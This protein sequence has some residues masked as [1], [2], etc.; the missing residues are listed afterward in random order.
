MG[1]VRLA[2]R[3]MATSAL[4]ALVVALLVAPAIVAAG[5][6]VAVADFRYTPPT[7]T[8]GVGEAVTWTMGNDP[9]QHTVTPDDAGSFAGSGIL[10]AGQSFSATFAVAGQYGYH[11]ELH[12]FMT[13][14]VIVTTAT[15]VPTPVPTPKP[16]PKPTPAPTAKPTATLQSTPKPTATPTPKPTVTPAGTVSAM[17]TTSPAVTTSP[18][19]STS[20]SPSATAAPSLGSPFP[21]AGATIAPAGERPSPSVQASGGAG[22]GEGGVPLPIVVLGGLVIVG[23][24]AAYLVTRRR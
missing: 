8:I 22:S 24:G 9:E 4:G 18:L 16:T 15:P 19:S 20:A 5:A 21:S 11:C 10:E 7:V 12:P 17:P 13:G 1:R 3:V 23:G 14:T 2:G 6:S